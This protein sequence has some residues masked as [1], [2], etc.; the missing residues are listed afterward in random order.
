MVDK[1]GVFF[2]CLLLDR[3]GV[4]T[5]GRYFETF[6]PPF[7]L[8]L[9][10]LHD[11]ITDNPKGFERDSDAIFRDIKLGI[12]RLKLHD[13]KDVRV[14]VQK[15]A[16]SL[17]GTVPSMAVLKYIGN[18][19]DNTLGVRVV[20]NNLQ[21]RRAG[22]ES[23]KRAAPILQTPSSS[24]LDEQSRDTRLESRRNTDGGTETEVN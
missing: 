21:L 12:S 16:V 18:V 8:D 15:Q 19:A 24:V 11:S 13:T 6:N 1:M 17:E 22:G 7:F 10:Y 4:S 9:S 3:S 23:I 20:S 5:V 2:E 14:V